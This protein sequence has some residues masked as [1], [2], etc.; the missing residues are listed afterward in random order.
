[1]YS[2]AAAVYRADLAGLVFETEAWESGLIADKILPTITVDKK[3][4]Q[5]PKFEKRE[6]KLLKREVKARGL[7]GAYPRGELSFTWDTYDTQDWGHELPVDDVV[8]AE[9]KDFFSAETVATKLTRRKVLLDR[10][11]RA[12]AAVFNTTNFGT[13]TNSATAYTV[14]NIATFDAAL[15]IQGL[16]D[17]LVARGE[18]ANTVVIPFQ[19]ATRL[20][21]STKFQN[22]ARGVG[23]SSDSILSL[24][25]GAMAEVIG[26]D[27]VF[28]PRTAYDSAAGNVAF[29][30]A[31]IWANTYIWVGNVGSSGSMAS[32]FNGGAGFTLAWREY[33]GD[34]D[35]FTYRDEQHVSDIV[36][37]RQHVIE[38]ITNGAAGLLL[39]TQYA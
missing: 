8:T 35:V 3:S 6:G 1:M 15:D 24:D 29:T 17:T 18:R 20:K 31:L 4:G 34:L 13:A 37:A 25:E 21:A 22:R 28:I 14:A 33:A 7:N 36:R 27:N 10:E 26:V 39:A 11:I 23:V 9:M 32:I 30:S 16:M 2:N 12:A 38:K 5:Y 19:V